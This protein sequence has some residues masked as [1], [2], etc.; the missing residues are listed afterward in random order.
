MA[1]FIRLAADLVLAG[2]RV[3]AATSKVVLNVE[4]AQSVNMI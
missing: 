3:R 2:L 1:N 4:E